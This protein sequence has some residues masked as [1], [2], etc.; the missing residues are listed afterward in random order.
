LEETFGADALGGAL[1]GSDFI[2]SS[3][4]L[5]LISIA[6][7]R[8]GHPRLARALKNANSMIY[9]NSLPCEAIVTHDIRLGHHGLGTVLHPKVRIGSGVKIFQNVTMAVRPPLGANE[10]VI[11]DGV[12]IGAGAVIITPR[13]RSIR[14]GRGASVG[15]GTVVTRD[16]PDQTIAIGLAPELRA[17]SARRPAAEE[18]EEA[19]GEG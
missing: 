2:L 15:A 3:R 18:G 9:H 1:R 14:I 12:V 6:L 4:R 5:W 16:V 10:I 17:R 11:E 7:Y 13:N 19:D 8:A